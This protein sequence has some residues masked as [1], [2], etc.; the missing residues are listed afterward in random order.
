[1]IDHGI[2]IVHII[3]LFNYELHRMSNGQWQLSY[4]F[5]SLLTAEKCS[6]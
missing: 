4:F 5:D 2:Q 6:S 1:M 3:D